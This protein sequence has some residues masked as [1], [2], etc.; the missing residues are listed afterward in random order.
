MNK[1]R[2]EKSIRKKKKTSSEFNKNCCIMERVDKKK[3]LDEMILNFKLR[4]SK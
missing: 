3:I 1:I 4:K 2:K